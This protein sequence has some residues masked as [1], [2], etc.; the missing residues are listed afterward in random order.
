MGSAI[1][2]EEEWMEKIT[3]RYSIN[4]KNYPPTDA[5][6]KWMAKASFADLALLFTTLHRG[7]SNKTHVA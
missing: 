6:V 4:F 7:P 3:R 5:D 2:N 1:E